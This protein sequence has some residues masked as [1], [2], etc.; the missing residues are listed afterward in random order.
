MAQIVQRTRPR[1]GLG[2]E[3]L[4]VPL[5]NA[6]SPAMPRSL[7]PICLFHQPVSEILRH[8]RSLFFLQSVLGD[9]FRQEGAIRAPRRI[10][11]RRNGEEGPGIVVEPHGVVEARRLGYALTETHHSLRTFVKPP[12]RAEPQA[13]V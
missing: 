12:R 6:V 5:S 10:V 8:F 9:K 2:D 13:R 11:P 3:L 1:R 7:Q 4:S